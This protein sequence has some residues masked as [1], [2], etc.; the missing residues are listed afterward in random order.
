MKKTLVILAAGIGSRYG[1]GVKQLAPVG[2]RGEIIIDY[3][4]HDAIKAGF[5]KI[6]FIIRHDIEADFR[7]IIGNRIEA[8]CEPLGVQVF[9]AFQELTDVPIPVPEGRTKPWGTGHAVLCCKDLIHEPFAVINADDYYGKDGFVKA[10]AFLEKGTYGMIA[11]VLK[12]T[13]S[14][15]GGVTRGLCN[16]V[17]GRLIG[18]DETK[19]I[20]K[21]PKG[22]RAGDMALVPS[23]LVS[24]NFWCLPESFLHVLQTGFPRFLQEM[25]DP[26]KDEY[27]LPIIVDGLLKVGKP[28]SVIPTNDTWFGVTYKEDKASVVESF[29]A[30]YEAGAYAEDLDSDL[31]SQEKTSVL[32]NGKTILV[33]GSPGFIGAHLVLRLLEDLQSGTVVSFDNMNDY[34]D[35]ALKEYR[36]RRIE[37]AAAS[38]GV[39]HVFVRGS[40]A[41]KSLVDRVFA[42]HR[43]DVVVNLA[44][45]DGVQYSIDH[46]DVCMESN[47]IGFYNILEACRRNPVEHL[48]FASSSSVYDD[49]RGT[50]AQREDKPVSLDVATKKSNELLAH[51]YSK[52]YNI[53]ATGLRLFSVY[54][55]AGRP[56]MFYYSAAR[57]LAAGQTI[58]IFNYGDMRRDFTYIDDI[59]EGVFRVMQGA[60]EKRDGEDALPIPPYALYNIGGGRPEN[61][62]DFVGTLQEELVRAGVLPADYDFEGH[63]ELVGMQPGDVPLTFADAGPLERDFGF[64][65]S[66]GIREGL[67]A[68][69]E[70][71]R[72]YHGAGTP[73]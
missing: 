29:R 15:H 5:N 23:T 36:L 54:G 22:I 55:P 73:V 6:I 57:Q 51:S 20:V 16:V 67:R 32:L 25:K 11:Y 49:G 45:Q 41:D 39:K 21:T 65:P 61:L 33:T 35:P 71:Y 70:W 52:L 53:P 30:L 72:E 48:V 44:A 60:P 8:L 2:P 43:P 66:V 58:R 10:A 14:D 34:Y 3:S 9:Y 59:V 62:L 1:G 24:M 38:S 19:N 26:L 17:G 7:E 31:R 64:K 4:I 28:V 69:A 27:L 46:P 37:D 68:F 18:I 56:D 12:N 50:D 47:L 13:L 42:E 40:I 63:R